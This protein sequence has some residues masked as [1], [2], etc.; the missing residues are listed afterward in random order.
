MTS[1]MQDNNKKGMAT[2]TPTIC[3]LAPVSWFV[4]ELERRMTTAIWRNLLEKSNYILNFPKT[5]R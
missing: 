4:R 5:D 3:Q 1:M 2:E